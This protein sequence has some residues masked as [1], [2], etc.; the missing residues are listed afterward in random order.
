MA[1]PALTV[2]DAGTISAALFEESAT[3]AAPES[4]AGDNVT[5]QVVVV[6]DTIELGAHEMLETAGGGGV[7]VIDVAADPFN[8][9]VTATV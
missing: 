1:A 5:V 4:A 8:V 7:T 9:A 3:E 2:T 6:V